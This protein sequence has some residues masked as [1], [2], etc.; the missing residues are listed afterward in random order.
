MALPPLLA[1]QRLKENGYS[2]CEPEFVP[3]Q[4]RYPMDGELTEQGEKRRAYRQTQE[5]ARVPAFVTPAAPESA[6]GDLIGLEQQKAMPW[7]DLVKYAQLRGINA[8]EKGMTKEKI[9]ALLNPAG[10]PN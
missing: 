2:Q 9:L 6:P 8:K 4:K 3:A 5:K 1:A 7:M 10:M